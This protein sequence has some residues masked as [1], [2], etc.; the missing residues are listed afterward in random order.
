MEN[1]RRQKRNQRIY[2]I[3]LFCEVKTRAVFF[4][5]NTDTKNC[6]CSSLV[7]RLNLRSAMYR[8]ENK[9]RQVF[10]WIHAQTSDDNVEKVQAQ[11]SCE[12]TAVFMFAV[13][14]LNSGEYFCHVMTSWTLVTSHKSCHEYNS[15]VK[16]RG[17]AGCG[18][19]VADW[20]SWRFSSKG[21]V[22]GSVGIGPCLC[23][24][25]PDVVYLVV[26]PSGHEAEVWRQLCVIGSSCGKAR[27]RG[28]NTILVLRSLFV[29]DFP[30]HGDGFGC[31]AAPILTW[32]SVCKHGRHNN[33][34]RHLP[35]PGFAQHRHCLVA[36]C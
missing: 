11:S 35:M 14:R 26:A 19:T 15:L 3:L 12:L 8:K 4:L 9:P 16:D 10:V 24:A 1:W 36:A 25:V 22:R 13:T 30:V 6:G 17:R 2:I 27:E 18:Y 31:S 5:Q 33:C 20:V 28:R 34:S 21:A 23:V 29:N 7:T 32:H